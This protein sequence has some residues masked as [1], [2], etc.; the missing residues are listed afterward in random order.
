M[1]ANK[2]NNNHHHHVV[3][4]DDYEVHDYRH[5]MR[6]CDDGDHWVMCTKPQSFERSQDI[7]GFCLNPSECK[8]NEKNVH[9]NEFHIE[10]CYDGVHTFNLCT[11]PKLYPF[12]EQEFS[13][14]CEESKMQT[15]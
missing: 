15:H 5:H 4:D 9:K 8:L 13:L 10:F 14:P 12:C 3:D 1:S 6:I 2:M 7:D 11:G